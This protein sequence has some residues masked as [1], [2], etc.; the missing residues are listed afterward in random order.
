[1]LPRIKRLTRADFSAVTQ[2]KRAVTGHF[3]ISYRISKTP[4]LAIVISKKI[5]KKAAERH[6][7]KRRISSVLE[8]SSFLHSA[9]VYARAGSPLLSFSELEAEIKELLRNTISV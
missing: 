1:M 9:V 6:L 2:G 8:K 3:S 4:K 5:A 7:L